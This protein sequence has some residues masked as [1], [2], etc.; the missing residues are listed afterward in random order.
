[1]ST[2]DL[3][4]RVDEVDAIAGYLAAT[5]G[6]F[7][8]VAGLPGVGKSAV[9]AGVTGCLPHHS[10]WLDGAAVTAGQL[11]TEEEVIVLD[12]CEPGAPTIA[13]IA[14]LRQRCPD[15]RILATARTP[16]GVDGERVIRLAPLEVPSPAVEDT[17]RIAG[18]PSVALFLRR[19]R[20]A[21]LA[22]QPDADELRAIASLCRGLDGVPRAIELLAA[23]VTTMAPTSMVDLV[24][25]RSAWDLVDGDL[26][27]DLQH[28]IDQLDDRS[29]HVLQALATFVWDAPV[30]AVHAI[31][32][33]GELAQTLEA[34]RALVEA[35]LVR[36]DTGRGRFAM[37]SSARRLVDSGPSAQALRDRH[38]RHFIDRARRWSDR[39]TVSTSGP[40]AEDDRFDELQD[41]LQ[42]LDWL[43]AHGTADEALRLSV[44]LAPGFIAGGDPAGARAML[45]E[46]LA[47][48]PAGADT[49]TRARA[50]LAIIRFAWEGTGALDRAG[51]GAHISA[52]REAADRSSDRDLLVRVLNAACE[53]HILWGE[54]DVAEEAARAGLALCEEEADD[55][56]RANFLGWQAIAAHQSGRP[57]RAEP[58]AWEAMRLAL[59]LGHRGLTDR[60]GAIYWGLPE[61]VRRHDLEV[62]PLAELIELAHRAGDVRG[63]GWLLTIAIGSALDRDDVAGAV[64]SCRDATELSRSSGNVPLARQVL[65][66]VVR[67]AGHV[68]RWDT[69]ALLEG[70]LSRDTLTVT[71]RIPPHSL[72]AFRDATRRAHDALG[73]GRR[74][75]L[76][77]RGSRLAVADAL[78]TCEG[79]FDDLAT[80][81]PVGEPSDADPTLLA[82]LTP[83][84]RAVL[85]HLVLGRSN[86]EIAEQLGLRAKTVMHHCAAIYQ[87]LGV[88]G[89]TA[90]VAV[91][92]RAQAR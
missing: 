43:R 55:R 17:D 62:P 49:S 87:K 46:S 80:S 15:V 53:H 76:L 75:A 33:A 10:S 88:K 24:A 56:T 29:R 63:E 69:A 51:V 12:G 86:K 25:G 92:V 34:L 3:V 64:T 37:L 19:A 18:A 31:G 67:L 77:A 35:D 85:D 4:G 45:V 78:A 40:P 52:A 28:E 21:D 90:A 73:T 50:H 70:V 5:P 36:S 83:R 9:A 7:A 60:T 42:A 27:E 54:L 65:A 1:M 30:D 47:L 44:D 16:L 91:A 89:R 58:L 13:A 6:A 23:Q 41:G 82:T 68:H 32:G 26:D 22:F 38:A 48:A 57:D 61:H 79:L 8:T 66:A 84:E 11:A 71:A 74:Q 2:Q 20:E 72:V 81:G 14:A 59:P 39:E